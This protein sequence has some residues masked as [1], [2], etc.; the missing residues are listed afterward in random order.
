MEKDIIE[1]LIEKTKENKINWLSYNHRICEFNESS[2]EIEEAFKVD[3]Q[4]ITHYALFSVELYIIRKNKALIRLISRNDCTIISY[5]GE[6]LINVVRKQRAKKRV[7]ILNDS[8][9]YLK[10]IGETFV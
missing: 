6:T 5:N 9:N 3:I 10:K 7:E 8:L 1:L 2:E 4:S